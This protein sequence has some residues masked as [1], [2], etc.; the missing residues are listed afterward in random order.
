MGPVSCDTF[1]VLPSHTR[2]DTM[3]FG[4]NSDRPQGEVQEVVYIPGKRN[5]ESE[6]LQVTY[7]EIPQVKN[8]RAVILSKPAWMWGAEMGANDLGVIIGNEAV[9]T[10][11]ESDKDREEK[12][13]GMDLVRLG[14]ERG[15]SAEHAL[16]TITNLLET[17]GQGGPCSDTDPDFTYHNSFLICDSKEAWVLETAG[18]LWAA[19]KITEGF[20]NISNCLSI[21]TNIDKMAPNLKEYCVEKKLWT[22]LGEFNFKKIIGSGGDN[23]RYINGRKL[24]QELS[25]SQKFTVEDMM[26]VLRDKP[27]GINRSY[28]DPFATAASQ[29]SV[30]SKFSNKFNCHYFTATPDPSISLFKPFLFANGNSNCDLTTSPSYEQDPAKSIPRFKFRVDRAHALYSKHRDA[31]KSNKITHQLL[32]EVRKFEKDQITELDSLLLQYSREFD[33]NLINRVFEQSV[34]KEISFYE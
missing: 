27:S 23:D 16:D 28:N 34:Q 22:G 10:K 3:I 20:R 6:Q 4:K 14:L 15:Y 24:L 29:I 25:T 11:L 21:T 5:S 19:E 18:H 17:H 12:L 31:V 2:C 8:T 7:I 26:K 32:N 13:L 33:P 9:Y 1:V 30:I